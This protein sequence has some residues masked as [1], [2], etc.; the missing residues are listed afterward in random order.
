MVSLRIF[1]T[2]VKAKAIVLLPLI[3]LW[4]GITWLGFYWHPERGFWQG[5]L[6]GFAT[7]LLLAVV[8]FGHA[9]AHIFSARYA[10]APMD[11]L[12]IS[13]D[14]PRTLVARGRKRMRLYGES[15]G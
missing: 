1:S 14:M 9:L 6:I 12:L 13:L 8:D 11:E 4:G 2:P 7:V 3:A 15:T 10:G 5:V